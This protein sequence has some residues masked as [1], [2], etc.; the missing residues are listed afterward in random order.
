MSSPMVIIDNFRLSIIKLPDAIQV[1]EDLH[2]VR[3]VLLIGRTISPCN[4]VNVKNI[5]TLDFIT[6]H[7]ECTYRIKLHAL[8]SDYNIAEFICQNKHKIYLHKNGV[9]MS[10][11]TLCAVAELYSILHAMK[12]TQV[13]GFRGMVGVDEQVPIFDVG[14][15]KLSIQ[16]LRDIY[17]AYEQ[18]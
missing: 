3:K 10:D 2:N 12:H 7:S 14:C 5:Y 15:T 8:W 11:H 17:A 9:I 16:D 6:N 18:L 1:S 13:Y 4:L